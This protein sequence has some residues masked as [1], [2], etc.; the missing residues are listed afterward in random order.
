M[1]ARESVRRSRLA[2]ESL[3]DRLMPALDAFLHIAPLPGERTVPG[4]RQ[5]I[6]IE[7]WSFGEVTPPSSSGHTGG[8]GQVT[9]ND[10]HLVMKVDKASADL[11]LACCTGKPIQ[12]ADLTFVTAGAKP[13]PYQTIQLTDVY[14]SSYR[15]GGAGGDLAPLESFSLNFGKA[16]TSYFGDKGKPNSWSLQDGKPAFAGGVSGAVGDLNADGKSDIVQ[17]QDV[18]GD[19]RPDVI[20]ATSGRAS[21]TVAVGITVTDPKVRQSL[22]QSYELAKQRGNLNVAL[23]TQG[24]TVTLSG[25]AD[26]VNKALDATTTLHQDV[27][28]KVV[29]AVTV[30]RADGSETTVTVH[31]EVE[32][33]A[34]GATVKEIAK[35]IK[36]LLE[37]K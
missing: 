26:D 1:R 35:A 17:R 2:V 15:P 24:E 8:G 37:G 3:E 4:H 11:L 32:V 19:G 14:V 22:A 7:S 12:K 10:F 20:G 5:P 30:K 36:E 33:G 28:V 6:Q 21:T 29:V 18:N 25:P 9:R 23:A 34:V 16:V 13:Q 27:K 31:V